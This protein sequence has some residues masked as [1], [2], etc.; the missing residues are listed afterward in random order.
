MQILEYTIS[1]YFGSYIDSFLTS[2]HQKRI[3]EELALLPANATDWPHS[4]MNIFL[5][6][7]HIGFSKDR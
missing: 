3:R 1:I 2:K 7:C 6:I 4:N 5:L